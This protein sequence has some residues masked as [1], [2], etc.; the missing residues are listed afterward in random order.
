LGL[1]ISALAGLLAG[2]SPAWTAARTE[3]VAGLRS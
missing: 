2:L 3:I 1:A